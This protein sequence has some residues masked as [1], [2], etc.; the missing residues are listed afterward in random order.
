MTA[1][2]AEDGLDSKALIKKVVRDGRSLGY[3]GGSG[4]WIPQSGSP[5][6]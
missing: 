6:T 2:K 3:R 4:G 1:S 5:W